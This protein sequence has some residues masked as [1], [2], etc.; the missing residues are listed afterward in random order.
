M[1]RRATSRFAILSVTW[2]TC[3][4]AIADPPPETSAARWYHRG[5]ESYAAGQW[6]QAVSS[7]KRA[8]ELDPG[9]FEYRYMLALATHECGDGVV[10]IRAALSSFGDCA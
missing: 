10:Q 2:A 5:C 6:D 1:S 7:L 3:C 9:E 4:L 8:A